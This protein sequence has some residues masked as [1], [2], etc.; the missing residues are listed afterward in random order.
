MRVSI[1][2]RRILSYKKSKIFDRYEVAV[3]AYCFKAK[4]DL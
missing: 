2:D 3:Y 1:R 4:V